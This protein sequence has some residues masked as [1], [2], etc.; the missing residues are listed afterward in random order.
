M[1]YED[2]FYWVIEFGEW[3]IWQRRTFD[4]ESA[5]WV[6]PGHEDTIGDP[7]WCDMFI[8]GPRIEPPPSPTNS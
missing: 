4:N 7:P 3:T 1:E 8:P 6:S 5:E 2:G